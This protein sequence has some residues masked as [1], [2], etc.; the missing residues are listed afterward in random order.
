MGQA[1]IIVFDELDDLGVEVINGA[2]IAATNDFAGQSAEP[3]LDLIEPGCV[4]RRKV[5]DH[6]FARPG[7][8]RAPL[9]S[10]DHG[11]QRTL[12]QFGD[13]PTGG[14]VPMGVEIVKDEVN[15]FGFSVMPTDRLDEIRE[16][17]GGTI[18]GEM[19]I[20]FPA[21]HFQTGSQAAS[22]VTDVLMFDAFNAFGLGRL[23]RVSSLKGLDAGLLI[24]RKNDLTPFGQ[25]LGLQVEGDDGQHLRLKVRIGTVKPVVPAMGLDRRLIE[26]PP[27]RGP[28]DGLDN[29]V[30]DDGL[31]EVGRTP[32]GDGNMVLDRWPSGQGHDLVLLLRGKTSVDGRDEDGP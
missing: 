4:R 1:F 21:G 12:T 24:N 31:G 11:W 5:K 9:V 22:P 26:Q 19:T 2:K 32:V 29:P 13:G 17:S 27:H 18:V 30:V 8:E 16:D 3:D 28:T 10:R 20:D 6:P 14:F 23:V 7:E 15:P 25:S